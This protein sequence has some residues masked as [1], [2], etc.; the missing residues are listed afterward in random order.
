[1]RV[2]DVMQKDPVTFRPD[3]GLA[4]IEEILVRCGITGAPVVEEGRLVGVISRSDL[5]RQLELERSRIESA[6]ETLGSFER[7]D[8][9]ATP[10]SVA[11]A[12]ATRWLPLKVKDVMRRDVV[13]V[14]PDDTVA[15][16][17]GRMVEHGIHRLAVTDG[18][19]LVGLV[20]T[21][22]LLAVLASQPMD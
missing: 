12:V 16:A 7:E 21:L 15:T 4:A 10:A 17:A 8:A 19:H 6:H 13:Q 22:D 20:S 11:M 9:F 14:S 2:A 18:G 5:V 3:Q 1:M